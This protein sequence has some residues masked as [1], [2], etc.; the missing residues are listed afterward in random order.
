VCVSGGTGRQGRT[1]DIQPAFA[2]FT[3]EK[4]SL[5]E[6]P[7]DNMCPSRTKFFPWMRVRSKRGTQVK[8]EKRKNTRHKIP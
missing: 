4:Q 8:K 6:K 2:K 7:F 5:H 1:S 3:G